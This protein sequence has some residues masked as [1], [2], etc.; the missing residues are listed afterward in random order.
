MLDY[1]LQSS[2]TFTPYSA[3]VAAAA[4]EAGMWAYPLEEQLVKEKQT[5]QGD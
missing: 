1:E 4:R 2:C 5:A 3:A